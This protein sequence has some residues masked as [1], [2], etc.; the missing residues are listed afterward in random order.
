MTPQESQEA[1]RRLACLASEG[2]V[3]IITGDLPARLDLWVRRTA[4]KREQ[5]VA[6]HRR[7]ALARAYVAPRNETELKVAD[8]W[9]KVLGIE[10]IGVHDSFFELGGHSLLLP[11]ILNGLRQA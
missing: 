11:Q 7:P 3:L 6:R 10:Q 5:P 8:T 4:N 1:F 2:Q 9:S